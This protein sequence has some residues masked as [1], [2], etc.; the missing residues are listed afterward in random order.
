MNVTNDIYSNY[1][2]MTGEI[3]EGLSRMSKFCDQIGMG[4]RSELLQDAKKK[5]QSRKFAVGILGEFKRG[6]STVIN[7]LLG[8]EIMPADILP[9][10][11]TMN[12]VTYDLQPGVQLKMVDGTTKSISVDELA[13]YVTKLDENSAKNA[14]AIEEA[15]AFYPCQFCKNG[16][17]IIDTPGLNDD[18]RMNKITEETVPKL[19]AVIMVL[20]PD[21][22][23]SMSEAEF[24]RNKLM[25]SD[26]GRLIF[27]VN[28]ID[29]IRPKDRPR[30]VEGIRTKIEKS[31]LD[32]TADVYGIES[33]QYRAVKQ[34]MADI[35]IY[36]ISAQNALDGRVGAYDDVSE[37][38]EMVAKSGMPE[39]EAA[40]SKML[41]EER[42]VLELGTPLGRL[43]NT[44]KDAK[45]R[46]QTYL[47]AMEINQEEFLKAQRENLAAQ[48]KIREEKENE[49]HN[50]RQR[51]KS[52]SNGLGGKA[53]A[54]YRDIETAAMNL[55]DGMTLADSKCFDEGIKQAM[56]E[57]TMKSI[58]AMSTEKMSLFCQRIAAE[59]DEIVGQEAV[60]V[61]NFVGKSQ[62]QLGEVQSVFVKNGDEKK[63]TGMIDAAGLVIDIVTDSIGIYGLGGI[64][65]GYRAA[66]VKGALVGGGIGLAANIG[67]VLALAPMGIVGLPLCIISCA[68]G[69]GVSKGICNAVFKK[70]KN[71]KELSQL[72]ENLKA[73][74]KENLDNLRRDRVLEAWVN[75][76]ITSQFEMLCDAMDAQC[77]S[78]IRDAEDTINKI[79][80]DL[81]RNAAEKQAEKENYAAL[82]EAIDSLVSE[83]EPV[84]QKLLQY[85]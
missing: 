24:V 26:I 63:K 81:T 36:P 38:E 60:K 16:V 54:V 13:N 59:I 20:V 52:V 77:E 66:G 72:K 23:F 41:T 12:R 8:K 78:A 27:L 44:A 30:V 3:T 28:K 48:K 49:K 68:V 69:T 19:D 79:K 21:N 6:K 71:E 35:R 9:C 42:G 14:E 34:K 5:L 22:P 45:E 33:E 82:A 11:A 15:I 40:L 84:R 65:S 43:L 67:V 4:E 80:M 56:V 76:A 55:V 85:A 51:A 10:S 53:N 1:H 47:G 57:D 7:A 31:V 83:L 73:A 18:E 37:N 75:D 46:I 62:V 39:F 70:N 29:T 2:A 25:C 17:E 64:I 61:S 32:K 74:V 58:E 50:L